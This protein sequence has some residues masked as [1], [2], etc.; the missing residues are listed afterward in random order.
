MYGAD[1]NCD[2]IIDEGFDD[3]DGDST[4]GVDFDLGDGTEN[5]LDCD[6]NDPNKN[7]AAEEVCNGLDDDCDGLVDEEGALG[8]QDFYL[9]LDGDQH[10][11][12]NSETRCFCWDFGN[13][14]EFYTAKI[15]DDC[16]DLKATSYPGA[17]EDCNGED[18]DCDDEAQA[19]ALCDI[20]NEFG[21]CPARNCAP[22]AVGCLGQ[23]PTLR[24]VTRSTMT[25]TDLSMRT[26]QTS[27]VTAFPI[28]MTTTTTTTGS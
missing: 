20:T 25:V 10:G 27:M 15:A 18:D 5:A 24:S 14:V 16:N 13:P 12:P 17:D 8:C 1:D 21:T 2:G 19:N 28:A 4:A 6:P 9:D 22:K 11:D 7:A 3:M 23:T 26:F